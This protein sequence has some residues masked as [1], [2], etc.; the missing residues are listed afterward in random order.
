MDKLFLPDCYKT[1]SD[2]LPD[3][4]KVLLQLA[5]GLEYIHSKKIV[6]LD[7]KPQNVLFSIIPST[8][9]ETLIFKWADFGQS[10]LI[11]ED[12]NV[13]ISDATGG[14]PGTLHWTAPEILDLGNNESNTSTSSSSSA[15]DSSSTND[16]KISVECDI[17]SA[18]CVFFYYITEGKH[19]FGDLNV[20]TSQIPL[21]VMEGNPVNIKERKNIY[22]F[23]S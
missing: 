9:K 15:S 4:H 3:G 2:I 6:H 1:Y 22:L 23:C 10:K 20:S 19:P 21:N 14:R 18:G 13:F 11:R 5:E 7:I 8:K 16:L 17:W 12:G